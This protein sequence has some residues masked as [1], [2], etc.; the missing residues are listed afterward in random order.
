VRRERHEQ[1]FGTLTTGTLDALGDPLRIHSPVP[2]SAPITYIRVLM[3]D[4]SGCRFVVRSSDCL[5]DGSDQV[6]CTNEVGSCSLQEEQ[7]L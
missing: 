2:E 5:R 1:A 7:M 6:V 4:I 3:S